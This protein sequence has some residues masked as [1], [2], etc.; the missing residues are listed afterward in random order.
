MSAKKVIKAIRS[1]SSFLISSHVGA[2]GDA[3][4]GELAL[5][6]LLTRLGKSAYIVNSDR[7]PDNYAFL[8]GVKK[9]RGNLSK[10][11][12]QAAF[13]IDCP[14][15][16][17][18]GNV[19]KLID[20]AKPIINIDHHMDNKKFGQVN[21]IDSKAS[22]V[23]EMIYR[24]FHLTQ[25]KLTRND[26]LNIYTAMLTD[27]GSFRHANTDSTTHLI[28]GELLQLGIEPAKIYSRIYENNSMQD[29]AIV[30]KIISRMS[31]AVKNKI[32]WV[33]INKGILKKMKSRHEILDK[34]FDFAKSIKTVKTVIVFCQVDE[35][36]VKLSLRSKSPID[37]QKIAKLFSGGGHK[38]ASGCTI[39]GSLKEAEQKV[40]KEIKKALNARY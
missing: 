37:V 19:L 4:G 33:K 20:Q 10:D 32:A 25:T 17:R 13:I 6:S 11:K 26:A 31:F 22:S 21:W 8:P 18:I 28:A 39:K 35:H 9:I 3:L 16:Q 15:K 40:L 2:E 12:F 34:I 27:T 7:P 1:Y 5:A 29:A 30:A 23:G 14:D 36:R 38:C 24:L